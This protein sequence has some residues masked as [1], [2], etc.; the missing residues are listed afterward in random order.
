ME[1]HITSPYYYGRQAL[2][3]VVAWKFIKKLQK[4][5]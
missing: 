4:D 1:S 5:V 2:R 3:A